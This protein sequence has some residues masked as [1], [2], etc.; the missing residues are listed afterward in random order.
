MPLQGVSLVHFDMELQA[1]AVS[2]FPNAA[3]A[4]LDKDR[5]LQAV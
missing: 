5:E 2:T 1:P 4:M 3:E